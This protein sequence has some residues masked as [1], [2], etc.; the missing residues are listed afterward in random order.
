[1][2]RIIIDTQK[3]KEELGDLFGI[4]FEDINHAADGGLYAELIQNR[5]F[6]FD[7][8]DHP[9]YHA[10]TA[11]EEVTS[12][13]SRMALSVQCERSIHKNNPHYLVMDVFETVHGAGVRNLGFNSGIPYIHGEE[14]QFSCFMACDG[15]P[16][17][18]KVILEDNNNKELASTIFE[19][20]S[21]DWTTY[22]NKIMCI[23][24]EDNL[25]EGNSLSGRLVIKALNPGRLYIDM[26]SLFPVNTFHNRSNGMRK[27]L[28]NL[29]RD[30][31]P[32]FMRFPGGCL[33]HD[34][35]IH[36][37][38]RDSM[39]RWK[40][41]I[42]KLEERPARRN[43]W[44]YNQ[45]LGLGYYEY[46]LF[47]EDIGTKPLPVL[48]AGYDPHHQR[49]VPFEQL[50]EW[51]QDALD[52]I[53]FANGDETTEWGRKR[54]EL[55]HEAPFNLEYIAIGNEEV[56][57]GFFE[58]YPYFHKAIKEKYPNIK[59]IN[60]SGPFSSG[61]EYDKGWKSARDNQS[62]LVDEHYYQSPEWFLA[63]HHH[64]DNFKKEDPKVFLGEYASW[65]NTWYNALV[66]ASYMV[67]LERNAHAVK[68]ACYAP[69]FCN[70]DY[71]NWQPDMIWFN[72]HKAYGTANYYVQKLFMNHQGDVLLDIHGEELS[73]KIKL[74]D[75]TGHDIVLPHV[76]YTT[77]SYFD[78]EVI[79]EDTKEVIKCK[80]CTISSVEEE[81]LLAHMNSLNYTVKLKAKKLSG[82][83]GFAI[84][85]DKADNRNKRNWEFGGW[86]N[87][88]SIV[89]EDINGRNSVLTHAFNSVNLEQVYDLELRVAKDTITTYIDGELINETKKTN[90]VI[91][92][93][94]F[95]SSKD[96]TTGEVILKVVNVQ[97][98]NM[99]ANVTL[100][101]H[102]N[103]NIKGKI[104]KMAGYDLEA[105][106][107]FDQPE[108]VKPLETEISMNDTIFDYEFEGQSLTVIRLS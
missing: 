74:E 28:A 7:P 47:C 27:D 20:N 96:K 72:N 39:Y 98:K 60:S 21:K 15:R 22:S 12:L 44:R 6:E 85:F 91:E 34:G 55:G 24:P 95:T 67:G 65:G 37:D 80:D 58:R 108:L 104:Y 51:V 79:N 38:D 13:D 62:D 43:N 11:W 33:V 93:L 92:P 45:T 86:Q 59:V 78:I 9:T 25:Q 64:Y 106:N 30:M 57:E 36:S 88:D 5:S 100:L 8:I 54:I 40:N 103:R 23:L 83:R 2:A 70:A 73:E 89:T 46:F 82:V 41:T 87:Q 97:D 71:I 29:L 49:M 90:V 19:V 18:V 17:K 42:G 3:E 99:K 77:S 101:N 16:V 56:G 10:L 48:P 69:L 94:Y 68:L 32:K 61:S 1:M 105:K 4:F 52:L 63:H 50:D 31:K 66:E 26:V 102:P 75:T 107:S 53:E 14:Y 81:V 35:S 76:P 84:Q